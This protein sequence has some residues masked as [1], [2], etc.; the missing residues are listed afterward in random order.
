MLML[1][2]GWGAVTFPLSTTIRSLC[3]RE[4]QFTNDVGETKMFSPRVFFIS[5]LSVEQ[6]DRLLTTYHW[7]TLL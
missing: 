7:A 3:D 1:V 6:K 4:E 5:H 2:L